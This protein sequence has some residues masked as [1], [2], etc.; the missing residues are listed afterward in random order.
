MLRIPFA[1]GILAGAIL[2]ASVTSTLVE[3]T[4]VRPQGNGWKINWVKFLD[5]S[6]G[7]V[8]CPATMVRGSPSS[9]HPVTT[10][11]HNDESY[12]MCKQTDG[13]CWIAVTLDCPEQSAHAI[14]KVV[15]YEEA[16]PR[17][18]RLAVPSHDAFAVF[19][20]RRVW[21]DNRM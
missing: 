16:L 14:S 20:H 2:V 15:M 19:L 11:V 13:I 7:L 18:I 6:G 17:L 10:I 8:L 9:A 21:T 5:K 3:F 12:W 1:A 4:I